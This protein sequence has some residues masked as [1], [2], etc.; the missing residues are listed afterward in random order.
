MFW[1]ESLNVRQ[2]F[3]MGRRDEPNLDAGGDAHV[4][5]ERDAARELRQSRWWKNLIQNAKC[6]YCGVQLTAKTATMDHILPVSR[7]GCST[8][9]NVVASC[10]ACNTAKRDH[11]FLDP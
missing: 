9:G 11:S 6:H 8:K 10:K 1:R 5:R 4:R 7:G 2:A 3:S